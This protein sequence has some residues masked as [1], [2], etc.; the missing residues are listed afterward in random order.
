[1]DPQQPSSAPALTA[2][3]FKTLFLQGT[4]PSGPIGHIAFK[5]LLRGSIGMQSACRRSPVGT[6]DF[7]Q[8]PY[9][10]AASD[11][12]GP[13][14]LLLT[15]QGRGH[16]LL[17]T[18]ARSVPRAR[19]ECPV[20]KRREHDELPPNTAHSLHRAPESAAPVNVV[21]EGHGRESSAAE[22]ENAINDKLSHTSDTYPAASQSPPEIS[23]RARGLSSDAA[24]QAARLDAE[25]RLM[26]DEGVRG[27]ARPPDTVD[28]SETK[29][30]AV[31]GA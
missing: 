30:C 19:D 7:D 4:P 2:A 15:R 6:L 14:S 31:K 24:E 20:S 21:G 26:I 16:R 11:P 13:N 25:T 3:Q 12:E 10:R 27:L 29:R 5:Q 28:G 9:W 18:A 23:A 22:N 1:M 8:I 17:E